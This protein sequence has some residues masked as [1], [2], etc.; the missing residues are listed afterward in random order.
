MDY[1]HETQVCKNCNHSFLKSYRNRCGQSGAHQITLVHV[2]HDL[3]HAFLHADKGIFSFMLRI[4]T[5]P[6]VMAN[7]FTHG[8]RKTFTP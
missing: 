6:G 4:V 8:K 5:E 1:A 3:M 7:E 2:G